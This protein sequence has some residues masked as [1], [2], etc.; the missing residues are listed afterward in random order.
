M[1][2]E[3]RIKLL[4][5]VIPCYKE[6]KTIVPTLTKLEAVLRDTGLH[7]EIICVVDGFLDDTFA[8]A[9]RLSTPHLRVV[10]YEVNRGKG[11][12]V[13]YGMAR[14]K[15]DV[16][17]FMDANGINPRSLNMLLQ[18]FYWYNADIIVGSKRHPVSKV[19]YPPLRR[20]VSYFSQKLIKFLLGIDVKDTQ[21]GIKLFRREVLVKVL[22]RLLVKEF[23]FDIEMLA[24]AN[25]LGFK[26]IFESPVELEIEASLETSSVF[27]KGFVKQLLLTLKDTLAVVYR[28]NI[29]HYYD[30]NSH[31][32]WRRN[33]DLEFWQPQ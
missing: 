22:P 8:I 2:P 20:L 13:R 12:A 15:G 30:D 5:I 32:N 18:H 16:I 19:V 14:A 21:V 6:Q 11:H 3:P 24:V 7:Y 31:D 1:L 28:I 4:S 23:A 10:G 17:G 25:Y 27:K 26:R 29:R 9:S 33:P